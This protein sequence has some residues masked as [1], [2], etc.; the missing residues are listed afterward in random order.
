LQVSPRRRG[1][2]RAN[3]SAPRAGFGSS[4]QAQGTADPVNRNRSGKRFI[5][6]GAGNSDSFRRCR[7]WEPVH[8]R[9]RGEQVACGIGFVIAHGSSPQA[10]G[11]AAVPRADRPAARFIPAGAGNRRSQVARGAH[12][13][14]H[15]RRR[16]EQ[17]LL[18]RSCSPCF[19]SS[20]QA[21]GT[22]P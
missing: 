1:E 16:G 15:P 18:R 17:Y 19:G 11:T 5:P 12:N 10:R 20:P 21:R 8:P 13:A 4:P 9:R 14:V 2:Q 3:H 6:A 7:V 22:V